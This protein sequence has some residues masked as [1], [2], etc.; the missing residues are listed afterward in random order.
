MTDQLEASGDFQMPHKKRTVPFPAP[1]TQQ[2]SVEILTTKQ[3]ILR[4]TEKLFKTDLKTLGFTE[5]ELEIQASLEESF[6]DAA[7]KCGNAD[8]FLDYLSDQGIAIFSDSQY[9]E[10]NPTTIFKRLGLADEAFY[11]T[12]QALSNI[13]KANNYIDNKLLEQVGF[14]EIREAT[15]AKNGGIFLFPDSSPKFKWH[16]GVHAL[17]YMV[18]WSIHRDPKTEISANLAILKG[19]IGV[20]GREGLWEEVKSGDASEISDLTYGDVGFYEGKI[21]ESI[22]ELTGK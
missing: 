7:K 10:A 2:D 5:Q 4:N 16:E 22:R 19:L 14:D 12:P 18:G 15:L 11:A 6:Y 17:Q 3:I 21:E 9:L 8:S 20:N 13:L 1:A